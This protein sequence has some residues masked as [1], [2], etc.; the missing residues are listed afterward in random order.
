MKIRLVVDQMRIRL[1][2]LSSLLPPY[3]Q[4]VYSL[5]LTR[6]P[7]DGSFW[8]EWL[9]NADPSAATCG[10][11]MCSVEPLL[12][13]FVP[14]TLT[15]LHSVL[16]VT[17]GPYALPKAAVRFGCWMN[18]SQLSHMA[19]ANGIA[20]PEGTGKPDKKGVRGVNKRDWAHALVNHF[21]PECNEK[22]RQEMVQGMCWGARHSFKAPLETLQS[23]KMLDHDNAQTFE[24]LA[25][26]AEKSRE[27]SAQAA[28]RGALAA[29]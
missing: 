10:W 28:G 18:K 14:A 17:A 8:P 12:P 6:E 1:R 9:M 4:V 29:T 27:E 26:L 2:L 7:A 24:G 19:T 25:K 11:Q 13:A 22:E 5:D 20:V 21:F 16:H 3:A 23:V 15:H